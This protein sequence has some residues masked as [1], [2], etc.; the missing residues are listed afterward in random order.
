MSNLGLGIW[1]K[2][3]IKNILLAARLSMLNSGGDAEYRR[4]FETALVCVAQSFGIALEDVNGESLLGEM[5]LS[6]PERTK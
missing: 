6:L 1:F 2:D 3:E 5:M 4:G